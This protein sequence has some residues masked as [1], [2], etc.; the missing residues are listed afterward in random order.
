MLIYISFLSIDWF[1]F[2][3]YCFSVCS[4]ALVFICIYREL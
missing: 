1:V 2:S 3:T 4:L